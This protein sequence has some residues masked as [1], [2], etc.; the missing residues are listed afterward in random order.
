MKILF[1]TRVPITA[2]RFILPLADMLRGRGDEVEFAFGPGEGLQRMLA[3]GYACNSLN[4]KMNS[5]SV[6]NVAAIRELY[7]V[8]KRGRYDVVHTY[9]PTVGLYGRI[10]AQCAGVPYVVHSVIGSMAVSGVPFIHRAIYFVTELLTS[11]LVDRFVTL[12]EDDTRTLTRWKMTSPDRITTLQYEYGVDLRRFS[13]GALNQ[14]EIRAIRDQYRLDPGVP[15]IGFVG[16]LIEAKGVLELLEAFKLLRSRGSKAKLLFVGSVLSTDKDKETIHRLRRR[17][18]EDDLEDDVVFF[19]SRENVPLFLSLMDVVVLPSYN[20]GFPR[21]PI[22]AG[23]MGKPSICT[24]VAGAHRAIVD[25]ETGFIV[26]LYDVERLASAI[27][28]L[29]NDQGLLQRM[30]AAALERTTRLFD[31]EKILEQQMTVYDPFKI[32]CANA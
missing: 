1:V 4:L 30:G 8:I 5:L 10:A 21:I 24:A 20:E 12:N 22:E 23:A 29:V 18:K 31:Q 28:A 6:L 16:R 11:R 32:A 13:P 7:R 17:V 2:V 9:S 27:G 3:S 26:P 25:G 19:G 14:E 15:T